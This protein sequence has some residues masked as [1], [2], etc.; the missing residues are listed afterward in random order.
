M[1]REE[2]Y[3]DEEHG[4]SV[5]FDYTAVDPDD[6]RAVQKKAFDFIL[7]IW[8]GS[9]TDGAARVR[10]AVARWLLFKDGSASDLARKLKVSPPRI[11]QVAEE[12]RRNF[13]I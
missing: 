4:P 11:H 7:N 10:L 2:A 12:I 5:D 13:N 6:I 8:E 3:F 9:R 1:K